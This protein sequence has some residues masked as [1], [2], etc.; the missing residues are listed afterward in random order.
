MPQTQALVAT[1]LNTAFASPPPIPVGLVQP[2]K[3]KKWKLGKNTEVKA[4]EGTI[5]RMVPKEPVIN[6]KTI[7]ALE[8][9]MATSPNEEILR[10]IGRTPPTSEPT[11]PSQ[12]TI[13]SPVIEL[14]RTVGEA[15]FVDPVRPPGHL[16][17]N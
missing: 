4:V 5:L 6:G 2:S 3:A 9:E 11:S 12:S 17:G 14:N 15:V 7:A 10:N 16:R 1:T 8:W 13:T